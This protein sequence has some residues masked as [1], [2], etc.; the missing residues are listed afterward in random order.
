MSHSAILVLLALGAFGAVL[1]LQVKWMKL[2]P[3]LFRRRRRRSGAALAAFLLLLGLIHLAIDGRF[4]WIF[5]PPEDGSWR[6]VAIDGRPVV[7][8]DFLI[9]IRDGR[10]VGGND[11][12]NS[13]GF[14]EDNMSKP[15]GE[16][17][18]EST[19]Q[20]C[21]EAD[22]ARRA[23]WSIALSEPRPRAGP[24]GTLVIEANGHSGSFYRCRWRPTRPTPNS[25]VMACVMD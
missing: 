20:L 25:H 12:C 2:N 21:D 6:A 4:D 16:R 10:V 14:L 3:E 8:R 11:D 23:F 9:G 22:P 15:P 24:G 17:M 1:V 7:D 5:A 19:L 18:I 13:W